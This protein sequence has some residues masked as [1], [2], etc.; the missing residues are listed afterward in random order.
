MQVTSCILNK[1]NRKRFLRSSKNEKL[2]QFCNLDATLHHDLDIH[3]INYEIP[4]SLLQYSI[5][6][7][8]D[9]HLYTLY[10]SPHNLKQ[11]ASEVILTPRKVVLCHTCLLSVG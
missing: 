9:N 5:H 4:V 1:T 8:L 3:F 6:H 7:E 11:K 10:C 2:L